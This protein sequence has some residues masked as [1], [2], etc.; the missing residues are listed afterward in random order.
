MQLKAIG[1]AKH[2]YWYVFAGQEGLGSA[3]QVAASGQ[4]RAA[5][6]LIGAHHDAADPA[7]VVRA[8]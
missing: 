2:S 3:L 8:A 5:D 6:G 7:G 1:W 4:A